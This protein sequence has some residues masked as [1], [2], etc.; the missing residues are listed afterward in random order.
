MLNAD[1]IYSNPGCMSPDRCILRTLVVMVYEKPAVGL[2]ELVEFPETSRHW[3]SQDAC[4][5]KSMGWNLVGGNLPKS[6]EETGGTVTEEI[7]WTQQ[8]H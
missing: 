4:L 6:S 3:N 7:P 5:I 8:Y 1:A 2:I